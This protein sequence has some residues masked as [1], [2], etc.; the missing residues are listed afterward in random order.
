MVYT[1]EDNPTSFQVVLSSLNVDLWQEAI[2]DDTY[3][4]ESNKT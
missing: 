4:L 3:S 2:K 1:L